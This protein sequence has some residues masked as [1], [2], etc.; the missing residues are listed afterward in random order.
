MAGL[1]LHV[2]PVGN[3]RTLYTNILQV[4]SVT[5][6]FSWGFKSLTL[7]FAVLAHL[8]SGNFHSLI[9]VV[10]WPWVR[11][12]RCK[13]RLSIHHRM[14]FKSGAD[15]RHSSGP[16]GFNH[17]GLTVALVWVRRLSITMVFKQQN[18]HTLPGIFSIIL[19]H[20]TIFGAFHFSTTVIG[21]RVGKWFRPFLISRELETNILSSYQLKTGKH[22]SFYN[23]WYLSQDIRRN[24]A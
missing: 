22:L 4:R 12:G 24:S 9:C 1:L 2:F 17:S 23:D 16:M 20:V 13:A 11:I 3:Q 18:Y 8:N 14:T 15:Y 19:Q 7:G 10:H 6:A 5:G 21:S